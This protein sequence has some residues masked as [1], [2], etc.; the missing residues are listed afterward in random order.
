MSTHDQADYLKAAECMRSHGIA[1]FADPV[2]S[3]G[4][5]NFPIPS[6]MDANSTQF[7]RAREICE[8]LVPPGLPYSSRRRVASSKAS[9]TGGTG[10]G[11]VI[12]TA[13][14]LRSAA[15]QERK[16]RV[17]AQYARFPSA[18]SSWPRTAT[19][20]GRFQLREVEVELLGDRGV[21][22]GRLLQPIHTL[23][24]E[25]AMTVRRKEHE[26]VGALGVRVAFG[27]GL[28]PWAV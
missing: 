24:R 11:S 16:K 12:V 14:W 5:V 28:V 25:A 8:L 1:G 9:P 17:P 6:G 26:P 18:L 10:C 13:G 27:R 21:R 20:D 15:T 19:A 3:G 2:F 22:P 4:N 7:R 23:E